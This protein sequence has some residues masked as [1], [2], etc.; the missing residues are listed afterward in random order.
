[1]KRA[2]VTGPTGQDGSYLCDLLI[3]KGYEVHALVRQTTQFTP[4]RWGHLKNA[5]LKGL[6]VH[7]GDLQDASL[8]RTLIEDIMPD[9]V[10]NL[11]AQSHVGQ[12]LWVR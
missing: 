9:E 12:S 11:G 1:M 6:N 2:F 7:H 5:M 3:E 4:D 10:Y 8:M